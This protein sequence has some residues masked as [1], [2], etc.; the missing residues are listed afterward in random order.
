MK[1]IVCVH[2][3]LLVES[4]RGAKQRTHQD[5]L[6]FPT[7]INMLKIESRSK[8]FLVEARRHEPVGY[9]TSPS[10]SSGAALTIAEF[11]RQACSN[12]AIAIGPRKYGEC[13][14]RPVFDEFNPSDREALD[15]VI[16]A[17]YR[18][19]FG[20][21]NPTLNQRCDSLEA[22]L[23]NGEICVRDFVAGLATSQFYKDQY[24]HNVSPQRGIE[25]NFKHLLGRPPLNHAEVSKYIAIL[26]EHGFEAVIHALTDSAEYTEVFG[27]DI[28]PYPRALGSLAGMTTASFNNM[29]DLEASR[30]VSDNALGSRSRIYSQLNARMLNKTTITAGSVSVTLPT[31]QFKGH[32]PPKLEKPVVFRAWGCK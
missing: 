9:A 7:T 31:Q 4:S 28:V 10:T 3:T 2:A 18:Q 25:L 12:M 13:P 24:F 6:T 23:L 14:H 17:A 29:V 26:A 11:N 19:V 30:V 8:K 1:I 27:S 32:N 20:N 16:T 22:R 15:A 21:K 5:E